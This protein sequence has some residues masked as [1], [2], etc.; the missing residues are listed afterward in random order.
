MIPGRPHRIPHN[1]L[2][3]LDF[4]DHILEVRYSY[5]FSQP[6]RLDEQLIRIPADD[7]PDAVRQELEFL[8]QQLLERLP[9]PVPARLP[10]IE[11]MPEYVPGFLTV[12]IQDATRDL[13]VARL[14][15]HE[16]VPQLNSQ[17]EIELRLDP[18]QWSEEQM[19]SWR[20][21]EQH[22]GGIVWSDYLSR[23]GDLNP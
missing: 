1:L 17:R 2:V 13:P 20:R 19:S 14:Y 18:G 11:L 15:V 7:I 10:S 6:H 12:V 23:F 4:A 21:L 9:P 3:H 16:R 22:V 5:P 8:R